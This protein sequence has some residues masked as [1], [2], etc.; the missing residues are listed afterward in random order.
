MSNYSGLN[1][2]VCKKLDNVFSDIISQIDK[3]LQGETAD[4]VIDSWSIVMTTES[5]KRIEFFDAPDAA[6]ER[7]DEAIEETH[8][9]L[10]G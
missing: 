4:E 9:V 7:I 8:K 3:T 6:T 10:W 2:G 5:G 1:N